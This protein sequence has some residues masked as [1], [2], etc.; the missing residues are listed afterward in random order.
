M[1]ETLLSI[2][3]ILPYGDGMRLLD[4][5]RDHGPEH[6]TCGVT[7][8]EQSMFCE[9]LRGV[10]AWVGLEYMAQACCAFSGIEEVRDGRRP[11][12]GLLLGS[13]AYESEVEFFALGATLDVRAELLL[14]DESDLV[15]FACTIQHGDQVL[16]RG[17]VK[18]YRPKDVL[19][20][21]R[22]SR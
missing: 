13:R 9:G 1:T 5:L 15:A 14:R 8:H 17:D 2:E 19:A 21:I 16:A 20:L 10:P 4:A 22:G 7:V 12:I 3:S 18:A 11:S 6:V